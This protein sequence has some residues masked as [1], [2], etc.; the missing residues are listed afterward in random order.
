LTQ[1]ASLQIAGRDLEA[2]R[3][4]I[5]RLRKVS[6]D[7]NFVDYL[8]ARAS[9]EKGQ[10]V[11]AIEG[12]E[13]VRD[14]LDNQPNLQKQV[15]F[16][17]GNCYE[18]VGNLD[19]RI[20]A[21]RRA[22]R[23]D[24]DWE[25]AQMALADALTAAGRIEEASDI[26]KGIASTGRANDVAQQDLTRAMI[27]Q[28]LQRPQSDRNW[29]PVEEALARAVQLSPNSA[30]AVILNAEVLFA[31]GHIDAAGEILRSACESRPQTVEYNVY[32]F[33]RKYWPTHASFDRDGNGQG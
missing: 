23:V 33:C 28:T 15:D 14:R 19:Q 13:K 29:Q 12:F 7:L 5:A 16:S 30:V 2:A 18:R 25:P 1:K 20:S 26:Y 32:A 27:Q 31:Q 4:T 17:L 24:A 9:L 11:A 21:Y 3:Q 10:V 22:L 8:E 6:T